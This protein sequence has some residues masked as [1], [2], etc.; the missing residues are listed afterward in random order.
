MAVQLLMELSEC[1]PVLDV[2]GD[3]QGCIFYLVIRSLEDNQI[4][5]LARELLDKL[6]FSY[7]NVIQMAKANYFKPLLRLLSSGA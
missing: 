5:A 4:A 2:I 3:I 1:S 6:S 7:D